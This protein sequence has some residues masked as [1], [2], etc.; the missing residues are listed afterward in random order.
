MIQIDVHMCQM[1]WFNHQL[2][3]TMDPLTSIFLSYMGCRLQLKGST[4]GLPPTQ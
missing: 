1:G 3:T 4:L 2:E